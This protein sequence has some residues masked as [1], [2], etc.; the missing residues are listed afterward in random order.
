METYDTW[1]HNNFLK[2][3]L[4]AAELSLNGLF[5]MVK[6][7]ISKIL[8]DIGLYRMTLESIEKRNAKANECEEKQRPQVQERLRGETE[9]ERRKET[10]LFHYSP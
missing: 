9:K 4:N 2:G 7:F 10:H 1:C 5:V 3:S 8:Y 6:A